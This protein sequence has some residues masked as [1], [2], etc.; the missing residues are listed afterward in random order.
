M[1]AGWLLVSALAAACASGSQDGA[2]PDGGPQA[3]SCTTSAECDDGDSCTT[4]VCSLAVCGVSAVD[5]CAELSPV[6]DDGFESEP[7]HVVDD[8]NLGGWQA[9]D[10]DDCPVGLEIRLDDHFDYGKP[11]AFVDGAGG[12]RLTATSGGKVSLV[13]TP[14]NPTG[15]SMN[16]MGTTAEGSYGQALHP[17]SAQATGSIEL[18][19]RPAGNTKEKWITLDEGGSSRFYL[20]FDSDGLV[21][22]S[23]AGTRST[24]Q[25]YDGATWYQVRMSWDAARDRVDLDIGDSHHPD[26]HLHQPIA[27]HIDRLRMRTAGASGLSFMVDD[28]AASGGNQVMD[29]LASLRI[30]PG[31]GSCARAAG[32]SRTFDPVRA[33][34]LSLELQADDT[35]QPYL[36]ELTQGGGGG[37]AIELAPDGTLR[38]RG[39]DGT[40]TLPGSWHAGER[41]RIEL[42][43]DHDSFDVWVGD[44]DAVSGSG[45]APALPIEDGIDELHLAIPPGG[46]LWVDEVRVQSAG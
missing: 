7:G 42:R 46:A 13:E 15:F 8:G 18:R 14:E 16:V 29:G 39:G 44:D 5:H 2:G 19:V 17:V 33:G 40:A 9:V 3:A 26:L 45:L 43:W 35:D 21:K 20:Y 23:N 22:Y 12:W 6:L 24:L 1:R 34:M 38:W 27:H 25:S 10:S 4:D 41:L 31:D 37:A 36:I 11:A 28:V 32:A 30:G